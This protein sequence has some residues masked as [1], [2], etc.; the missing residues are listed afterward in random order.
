MRKLAI[1]TASSF[2]ML[3]AAAEAQEAPAPV[4]PAPNTQAA[5][6]TPATPEV[7][8]IQ[9]INIVD[10]TEL[11]PETQTQVTKIEAQ[12]SPDQLKQMR[13]SIDATPSVSSALQAKGLTSANVVVASL[14]GD[15]ALTLITRKAPG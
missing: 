4:G 2:F 15:G 9:S 5:P 1:F 12:S 3:A 10:F 7:P 13:S 14:N 8:S 11:P 6:T